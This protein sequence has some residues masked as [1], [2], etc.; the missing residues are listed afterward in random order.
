[1]KFTRRDLASKVAIS[2]ET[3]KKL[4]SGDRNPSVETAKKFA[5]YFGK[6]LDYLFPD[7]FLIDFDTKSNKKNTKKQLK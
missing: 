6:P 7:I 4:E 1:M 5:L 2:E 3:I